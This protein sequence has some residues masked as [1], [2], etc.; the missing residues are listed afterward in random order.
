MKLS[1]INLYKGHHSG[2]RWIYR[3]FYTILILFLFSPNTYSHEAEPVVNINGDFSDAQPGVISGSNDITNWT[4]Y[5]FDH[6]D[7]E[8]VEDSLNEGNNLLKVS[9]TDNDGSLDPWS[10]QA[11]HGNIQLEEEKRYRISLRLKAEAEST[12][13]IQLHPQ[14]LGATEAL[15]AQ[16][17]T[18]GEWNVFEISGF[19]PNA[20][21]DIVAAVHFTHPDNPENVIFYIDWIEVREINPLLPPLSNIPL[22]DG[23]DK[24]L[25]S[26]SS[27]LTYWDYYWNQLTPGNAGKW[28][29]VEH[30][31]GVRDWSALDDKYNYSRRH[32]VPFRYHVLLW[33]SQQP[34]W[35]EELTEEEQLE[36]IE[37]WFWAVAERYPDIEYLE[38]LNEQLPGHGGLPYRDALGGPGETGWDWI[39]NAFQ[40]ARDIF[41]ETTKLM[42]NDYGILGNSTNTTR[43]LEII[44]LLQERDLIDGIGV[45]G[46]HFT[47]QGSPNNPRPTER[48]IQQ[49]LDRLGETGLPVQVTELDIGGNPMLE[50][51]T[52]EES[53]QRQLEEYQR[54]F[55]VLWEHPSVEGI[56][57]WDYRPPGWRP[58][59]EMHLVRE[60]G[61]ERP[62][63]QWLRQ[64]LA[65]EWTTTGA[66]SENLD[67]PQ[68]FQLSQNY[69]NP[70]NPSTV[71][72]Y[73]L[74][75]HTHVSLRV[76]DTT[77][78]LVTTLVNEAQSR[79]RYQATFDGS[80]LS[81]GLY[82]YRLETNSYNASRKMMLVK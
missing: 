14:G 71:I 62:A 45:Q 50:D 49:T 6:V 12:A 31:Q 69:P 58:Q 15:W 59:Y 52:E 75:D 47:V 39:I 77:G 17:V 40:M 65:G 7:Y 24:F 79:G 10:A 20:D 38:V 9:F 66:I 56:T 43:Y 16:P 82:I 48:N 72:R 18:P 2:R 63:M 57:T 19:E 33:G 22:A 26:T 67:N 55:P 51:L 80:N 61:S 37:D 21:G 34:G 68:K 42:I 35:I 81:S 27:H 29:S 53:D 41:P 28:G 11:V 76:Y 25:G 44:G 4:F 60:D 13:R 73:E 30:E 23:H 70:F 36:A 64:Y 74:S 32:G 8:I 46:H 54:I 5:G 3:F 1:Y 78:R